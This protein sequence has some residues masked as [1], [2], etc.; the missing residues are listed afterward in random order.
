[1]TKNN[2]VIQEPLDLARDLQI[3]VFWNLTICRV[4]SK[5]SVRRIAM[6]LDLLLAVSGSLLLVAFLFLGCG[7]NCKLRTWRCKGTVVQTCSPDGW[8]K[9][10]DC[11]KLFRTG[12]KKY[13]CVQLP[14][15][16]CTCKVVTK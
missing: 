12:G 10:M 11:S 3:P 7:P 13:D 1:M 16:K 14:N 9:V 4:L 6:N 5:L 2:G 8:R 15:G